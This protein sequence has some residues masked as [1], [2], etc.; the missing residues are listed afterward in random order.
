MNGLPIKKVKR[1]RV[2]D[3]V[4][5]QLSELINNHTFEPGHKLPGEYTLAEQFAVSR[6]TVRE[7]LRMLETIGMIEII[8]GSGAYVSDLANQ[9]S[10]P[11]SSLQW[12]VERKESIVEIQEVRESLEGIGARL[13][14]ERITPEQLEVLRQASQEFQQAEQQTEDAETL[15]KA[16]R[17]FHSLIGEFAGNSLLME[18]INHFENLYS[19]AARAILKQVGMTS[20]YTTEHSGIFEAIEAGNGALTETLMRAHIS[21]TRADVAGLG[22]KSE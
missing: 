20:I 14:A 1:G 12:L 8:N 17:R 18:L 6:N 5:D 22:T 10:E 16:N 3:Q 21:N 9:L 15:L 7:A 4:V 13:C 19:T 2:S 11:S